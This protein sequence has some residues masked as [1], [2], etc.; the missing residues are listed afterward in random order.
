TTPPDDLRLAVIDPPGRALAGVCGLPHMIAPPAVTP[1]EVDNLVHVLL[2]ELDD[3]RREAG[4]AEPRLVV[5]VNRPLEMVRAVGPLA[6]GDLIH[7]A[8][9]GSRVGFHVLCSE[10]NPDGL[11]EELRACFPVRLVGRV[12]DADA[13]R[14]AS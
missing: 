2:R 14:R 13:A 8:R 7:L 10:P 11:A 12:A 1:R 4:R 6:M 5:A 3:R 9:D